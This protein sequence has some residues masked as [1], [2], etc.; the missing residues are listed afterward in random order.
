MEPDKI[1]G[2]HI[3]SLLAVP[4]VPSCFRLTV[5]FCL[6]TVRHQ[7]EMTVRQFGTNKKLVP[8]CPDT[9]APVFWC[10]SVLV[11]NCPGAEVS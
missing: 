7:S 6:Q 10:R 9:S 8:K 11:P 4:S 5:A 1:D 2:K 3:F